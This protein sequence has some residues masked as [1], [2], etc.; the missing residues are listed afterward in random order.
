MGEGKVWRCGWKQ[1][2]R[3]F[4]VWVANQPRVAATGA[5]FEEADQAMWELILQ[6]FGDGENVRDYHP[7]PPAP[8]LTVPLV[9]GWDLVQVT[10]NAHTEIDGSPEPLFERTACALCGA[11]RGSRSS[12]PLRVRWF[13]TVAEGGFAVALPYPSP[14]HLEFVSEKFLALLTPAERVNDFG[15]PPTFTRQHTLAR[16]LRLTLE[17]CKLGSLTWYQATRH[18]FASQWVLGG[19]PGQRNR[20]QLATIWLRRGRRCPRTRSQPVE[21]T[22]RPRSSGG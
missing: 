19:G 11:P 13:D 18:T 3:A 14:P 4:R 1:E 9:A 10:A 16:H 21:I 20:R 6:R 7:P 12:A 8:G 15:R 5:S 22:I 2:G 17:R